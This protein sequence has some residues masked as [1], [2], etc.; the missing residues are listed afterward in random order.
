MHEKN[1][2]P[3][4]WERKHAQRGHTDVN[5][6]IGTEISYPVVPT[7]HFAPSDPVGRPY[8]EKYTPF[9]TLAGL[10]FGQVIGDMPETK[11]LADRDRKPL[12]QVGWMTPFVGTRNAFPSYSK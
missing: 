1:S 7:K 6:S 9:R 11:Y 3:T 12:L 8:P 5:P 10:D 4:W 2:S